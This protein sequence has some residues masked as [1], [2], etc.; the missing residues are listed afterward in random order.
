MVLLERVIAI[1]TL[2]TRAQH[3]RVRPGTTLARARAR[4][5]A[6]DAL[7]TEPMTTIPPTVLCELCGLPHQIGAVRCDG[8]DH[9]LG[10][11]PDWHALGVELRT[12]R[13]RM[14][15]GVAAFVAMVALN[16]LVFQ[17]VGFVLAVAPLGWII[18]SWNRRRHVVSYL[19]RAPR[20]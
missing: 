16:V 13:N 17:G 11:A 10:N 6:R 9:V 18:H 19:G 15:M 14:W 5:T 2:L 20:S 7:V 12:L 8:C 1:T 3:D 4:C